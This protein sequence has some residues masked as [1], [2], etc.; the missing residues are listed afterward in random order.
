MAA[1]LHPNS[2]PRLACLVRCVTYLAVGAV[3]SSLLAWLL[4]AREPISANNSGDYKLYVLQTGPSRKASVRVRESAGGLTVSRTDL[5]GLLDHKWVDETGESPDAACQALIS[6]APIDELREMRAFGL[7]L[8]QFRGGLVIDGAPDITWDSSGEIVRWDIRLRTLDC[9]PLSS[10]NTRWPPSSAFLP[11]GP[12]WSGLV[13]NA[14]THAVLLWVSRAGLVR[15]KRAVTSRKGHCE[16]C[17]YP[18]PPG[19][20]GACPECGTI[21]SSKS[22]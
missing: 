16:H 1:A 10:P 2:R 5:P 13:C 12:I 17:Q 20:V 19:G 14:A 18:R 6:A 15:L 22:A 11:Y 9:L 3:T 7:P 4:A 21:P 8:L